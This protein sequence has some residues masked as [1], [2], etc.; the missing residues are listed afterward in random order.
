MKTDSFIKIALLLIVFS[1]TVITCYFITSDI[2][3][4][5]FVAIAITIVME[6]TKHLTGRVSH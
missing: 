6:I 3:A 4:S 1:V 2:F 5:I